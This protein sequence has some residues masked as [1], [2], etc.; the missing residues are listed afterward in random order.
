MILD[1]TDQ[2]LQ[3]IGAALGELPYKH[4]SAV[5]AKLQKQINDAN[6]PTGFTEDNPA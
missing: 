4:S 2:D 3:I 1:L 6:Q 5:I